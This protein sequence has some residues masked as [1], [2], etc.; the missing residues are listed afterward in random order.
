MFEK[1]SKGVVYR[2]RECVG[3]VKD[4]RKEGKMVLW[5]GGTGAREGSFT[6]FLPFLVP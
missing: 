5:V 4:G 1:V 6:Y 2:G 3:T